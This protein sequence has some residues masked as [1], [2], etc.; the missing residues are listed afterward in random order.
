MCVAGQVRTAV[1]RGEV[2]DRDAEGGGALDGRP[3]VKDKF[4]YERSVAK[5]PIRLHRHAHRWRDTHTVDF[6]GCVLYVCLCVCVCV[7]FR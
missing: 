1:E 2:C 3:S 5:V 4:R 7:C 6:V